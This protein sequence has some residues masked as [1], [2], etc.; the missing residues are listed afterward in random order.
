MTIP[1][2][3]VVCVF[4]VAWVIVLK[5]EIDSLKKENKRMKGLLASKLQVM[6]KHIEVGKGMRLKGD[7]LKGAGPQ[8]MR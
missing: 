6:D 3:C 7:Q 2:L 5:A 8:A 1:I 4:F